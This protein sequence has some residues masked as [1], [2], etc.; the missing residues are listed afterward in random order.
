MIC[1]KCGA[2]DSI[3]YMEEIVYE[4]CYKIKK[5]GTLYKS[6]TKNKLSDS[7]FECCYCEKCR[8]E[9]EFDIIDNKIKLIEEPKQ[10]WDNN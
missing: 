6:F 10:W 4:H 7:Q 3:R 8:K 5:D 2:I 1:P 9:F